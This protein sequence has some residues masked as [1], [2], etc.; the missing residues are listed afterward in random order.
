LRKLV[1]DTSPIQYLH[2]L[3]LLDILP[4][5]ADRVLV[6][7]AVAKEILRGLSAN[8]DL[9]VPG[10]LP[11]IEALS[12][13]PI[14]RKIANE[15]LGAGEN[16]V[17]QSAI[18]SPGAIAVLDD[19]LARLA[20]LRHGV[21]ITGTIGILLDAKSRGLLALFQP[22]LDRLATLGFRLSDQTRNDALKRA[23]ELAP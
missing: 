12:E 2:Q 21:P 6:P 17:I 4:K 22:H 16:A 3:G 23:G 1:C 9:P 13:K 18:D 5:L 10:N 7:D 20:A 8:L 14:D 15:G 19:R 11:W